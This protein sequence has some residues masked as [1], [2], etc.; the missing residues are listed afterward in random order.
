MKKVDCSVLLAHEDGIA[1]LTL[2]CW[3]VCSF[4]VHFIPSHTKRGYRLESCHFHPDN[5]MSTLL[6]CV[7]LS[8][9][10][11]SVLMLED[12]RSIAMHF[13]K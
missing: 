10:L 4:Y 7:E 12:A 9:L 8:I 13:L 3:R 1:A 5:K 2:N 11:N 6:K